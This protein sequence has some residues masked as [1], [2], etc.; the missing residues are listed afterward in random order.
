[1][2]GLADLAQDTSLAEWPTGRLLSMA[3]RLVEGA[4]AQRLAEQGVTH[5]GFLVVHELAQHA[6]VPVQTLASRSQVTPQTM[7]RTVDRLERDGMVERRRAEDDRRRVEVHLTEAGRRT[8][9]RALDIAAAEPDLM[10]QE[11][12]LPTLR[13]NLLAIIAH[14]APQPGR[15]VAP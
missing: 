7:T 11:V 12:D 6:G 3:G 9:A 5:A 4:W 13:A 10:G 1:M 8:Y 14:L 2:P 15:S